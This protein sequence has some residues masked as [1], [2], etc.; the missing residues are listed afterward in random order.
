MPTYLE[1]RYLSGHDRAWLGAA[2]AR[3]P[4]QQGGVVYLGSVHVRS[5]R[6]HPGVARTGSDSHRV[7]VTQSGHNLEGDSA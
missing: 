1:E 6:A 2:L 7:A 4:K 5:Q 3:L